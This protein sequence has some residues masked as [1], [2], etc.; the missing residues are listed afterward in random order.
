MTAPEAWAANG[1]VLAL[2]SSY[3]LEMF[4]VRKPDAEATGLIIRPSEPSAS[5]LPSN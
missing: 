1:S 5:T 2:P 4:D 3:P